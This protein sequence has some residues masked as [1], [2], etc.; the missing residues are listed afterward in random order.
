MKYHIVFWEIKSRFIP[1]AFLY[2]AIGHLYLKADKSIRFYKLLGTGRGE[3]FTPSDANLLI[4][5]LLVKTEK[6]IENLELIK[7]WR[8]IAILEKYYELKPI[9]SHGSWSKQ[10]PF[11]VNSIEKYEGKVAAITR[12]RIRYR[13]IS[14]FWRSVPPVV[15]DLRNSPGLESAI[16]IGESPI[17]LQGTFSVWRD[18]NSLKNF[19]YHN[20][21]HQ[22]VIKKTHQLNWYA[23][24]LFARFAV[25]NEF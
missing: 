19:A 3:T 8:K 10:Q 9:S 6:D 1:I 22:E 4:W 18:S 5:G 13:L 2:M 24:E 7:K 11:E 12:A 21:P 25:V 15:T 14:N 16:G 23:E 20:N 17:G